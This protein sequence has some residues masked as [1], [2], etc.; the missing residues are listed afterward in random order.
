MKTNNGLALCSDLSDWYFANNFDKV[1]S[2]LFDVKC[3][4]DPVYNLEDKGDRYELV[5]DYDDKRDE[6]YVDINKEERKLIVTVREDWQKTNATSACGYYGKYTMTVPEDCD[7]L[8][9]KKGVNEKEKKMIITFPKIEKNDADKCDKRDDEDKMNYE[10]AYDKL[11][12]LY[13]NVKLELIEANAKNKEL[14]ELVKI[15][16]KENEELKEKL[17][18]IKNKV[19][20]LFDK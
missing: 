10:E 18:N 19:N 5:V 17:T 13:Q 9:W 16:K 1:F 15:Y 3:W 12:I 8:A 6:A 11:K 4:R 2:N 20:K 7:I 14:E